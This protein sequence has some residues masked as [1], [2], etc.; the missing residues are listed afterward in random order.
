[1]TKIH[2]PTTDS[3]KKSEYSY[4]IE[5][6]L[7]GKV[8]NVTRVEL[9]HTTAEAEGLVATNLR[10]R[11]SN[12]A[13]TK[14]EDNAPK[15]SVANKRKRDYT[16]KRPSSKDGSVS[17]RSSRQAPT[18]KPTKEA[19]KAPPKRNSRRTST[20]DDSSDA[21]NTTSNA[22]DLYTRHKRELERSLARLE[23]V[24]RFG[25]FFDTCPPEFDENYDD[26]GEATSFPDGPP[27][28]FVVLKKR[29]EAGRYDVDFV[30]VEMERRKGIKATFK[31]NV[32]DTATMEAISEEADSMNNDESLIRDEA[33]K[34]LYHP[35]GVDWDTFNK[36]VVGMCDAAIERDPDGKELGSGHLGW[37]ANKIKKLM[38]E[39]Y[40]NYGCKRR[41]EMELSEARLKY[42]NIL[43]N[44]GNREAA[45]QGR[46]RKHAFPERKYERLETSSVICDGLSELDKSYAIYE[47]GT[48]ISDSFVGLA[49]TYDDSGQHSETWMKTV[50]DETTAKPKARRKKKNIDESTDVNE[51]D[52]NKEHTAAAALAKDDGVT[53]AQVQNT[54]QSLLIQVQDKVMTDLGVMN[55]P[56]ARSANWDDGD[57]RRNYR[58]GAAE[59]E[60]GSNINSLPEVAEQEVWGVDC[61]TRKNI[62]ALIESE[63]SADI[64]LEFME[65]WLLPA[66]NACPVN[67]AYDIS[68]AARILEG[69]PII[70]TDVNK[71]EVLKPEESQ[72]DSKV[73]NI[74]AQLETIKSDILPDSPRRK[75]PESSVFL[76]NALESKIKNS[77]PPWLKAAAQLIRLAADSLDEDDGFFRIHPKGHGE[78]NLSISRLL[79]IGIDRFTR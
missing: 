36:D 68:T 63:F 72:S 14:E 21:G 46:W 65:K 23:K 13:L 76:R 69:L 67:L 37:S 53:K 5:Y 24:D 32:D 26:A 31:E 11:R 4:D 56:E 2:P 77:G 7:G 42:E 75:A 52:K 35:V 3:E 58:G 9:I 49:Y 30:Q 29:F 44:C 64:A 19:I 10:E 43:N 74:E 55:Q 70:N 62:M 41:A 59:V 12:R 27:F 71:E 34:T 16:N 50:V 28:N 33:V 15:K 66:I 60:Q 18:K 48:S 45:M 47:L 57:D 39:M 38:E 51:Q 20:D 73:N 61:Y 17:S 78:R 1:M 54:M 25:F 79:E 22:L 40:T 6:V 8:S